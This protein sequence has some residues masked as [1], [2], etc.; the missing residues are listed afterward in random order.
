MEITVNG[1][2]A[3]LDEPLCLADFLAMRGFAKGRVIIEYNGEILPA[4]AWENVVLSPGD[5]ME[6][7]TFVGGG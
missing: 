6:I 4:A 5:R 2:A 1:K 7:V 3:V